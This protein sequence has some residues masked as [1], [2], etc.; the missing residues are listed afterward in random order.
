MSEEIEDIEDSRRKH[1]NTSPKH[2]KEEGKKA[3]Q[4]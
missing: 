3:P 4:I 1:K 2:Q